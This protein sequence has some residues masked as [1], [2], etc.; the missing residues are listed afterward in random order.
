MD[1]AY[2]RQAPSLLTVLGVVCIGGAVLM[3]ARDALIVARGDTVL[4]AGDRVVV[5]ALP[6]AVRAVEKLLS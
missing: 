3:S 4:R 2:L 1:E 6:D 5:F